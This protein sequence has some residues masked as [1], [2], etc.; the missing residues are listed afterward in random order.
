MS[1]SS[2]NR[3]KHQSS[4]FMAAHTVLAH[5]W[6]H[7]GIIFEHVLDGFFNLIF[8]IFFCFK[9]DSFTKFLC[10]AVLECPDHQF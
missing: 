5:F 9:K 4:F 3:I 6:S 1:F 7:F 8:Q 10:T 2:K